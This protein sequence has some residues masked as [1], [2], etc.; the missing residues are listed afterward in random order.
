M[1][2]PPV[3]AILPA[4]ILVVMPPR[5]SSEPDAP[6][7]ASIS[8]VMRSTSGISLA[9]RAVLRRRVVEPVDVG[10][11]HQQVR[12]RHRGDARRE[13]IVV[14]IADLV[15]GDGVVLVDHRHAAPFEQLGDRAARVEI[16]APLLGVA[17]R[18]QDLPGRNAVAAE[19][20]GPGAR[21]RDLPDRG[22]GLASSSLSGPR[23]SLSTARPSAIAP[24]DT[25][26]M[27]RFSPCSCRDV[28]GE[29]GQPVL[30]HAAGRGIDQQRRADLDDDAAEIGEA[31]GLA[32]HD[33]YLRQGTGRRS[34]PTML[35]TLSTS[36]PYK[37]VN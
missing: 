28:V 18:Q 15:G 31:R 36:P 33:F 26:R 34:G 2:M 16:A 7:I 11:Q 10:E 3:V 29:R 1:W 19:R 20:L 21:E 25:T 14:A 5:E 9:L 4:S 12:A 23:G 32:R 8:G 30:V 13:A 27:S 17:E 6:A 37:H 35:K 22:G 24:D